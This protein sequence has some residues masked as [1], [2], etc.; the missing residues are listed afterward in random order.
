[1]RKVPRPRGAAAQRT[2]LIA[3]SSGEHSGMD[4]A[5]TVRSTLPEEPRSLEDTLESRAKLLGH[6]VH[7]MLIVF[8]LGL[9]STATVFDLVYWLGGAP[10]WAGASF[11]MIVAGIV[12]GLAAGIFGLVDYLGIPRRTRAR[13]IGILHG[14]GNVLV[15]AVYAV[16]WVQRIPNESTP[17]QIALV[18]SACGAVLLVVTG[19]MGG[20]MVDRLGVGVDE[21]AHLN[22]PSSLRGS[23]VPERRTARRRPGVTPFA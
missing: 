17:P 6:S 3:R 8:P 14:I 16:S 11:L 15:L 1:M 23:P 7:Q 21:R 2:R 18:L 10:G 19:W 22:A 4:V 20:E 13:R 12:G 9:L 5:A